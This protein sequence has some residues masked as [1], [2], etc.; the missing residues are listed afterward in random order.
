VID[1][2]YLGV[3]IGTVTMSADWQFLMDSLLPLFGLFIIPKNHQLYSHAVQG[4]LDNDEF[5][6]TDPVVHYFCLIPTAYDKD[7][8]TKSF[9]RPINHPVG[10]STVA[11]KLPP[12][13][14]VL[15]ISL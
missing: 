3:W 13:L 5:Y 2:S 14:V 11:G 7:Y 9:H 6:Q 4:S 10:I 8:P 15:N 1:P 12:G